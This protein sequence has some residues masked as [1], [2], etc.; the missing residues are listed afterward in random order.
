MSVFQVDGKVLYKPFFLQQKCKEIMES[1]NG[2]LHLFFSFYQTHMRKNKKII[3]FFFSF[4]TVRPNGPPKSDLRQVS[5][6]SKH[7]V[8]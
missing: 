7:D 2:A 5:W 1:E 8:G 6:A 4:L 3:F